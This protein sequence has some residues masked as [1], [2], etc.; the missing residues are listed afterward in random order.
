MAD[1]DLPKA[2]GGNYDEAYIIEEGPVTFDD[3]GDFGDGS[4]AGPVG[5]R[6]SDHNR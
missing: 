2:A 1:T 3:P 4:A 6:L 5:F